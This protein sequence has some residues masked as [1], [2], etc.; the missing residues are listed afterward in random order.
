[1]GE[2]GMGAKTAFRPD[3]GTIDGPFTTFVGL[4]KRLEHGLETW[5]LILTW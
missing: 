1:M 2:F 3:R 5:A 4:H